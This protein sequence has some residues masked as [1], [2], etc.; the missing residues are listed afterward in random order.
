M[1]NC[2]KW[3]IQAGLRENGNRFKRSIVRVN[4]VISGNLAFH[5]VSLLP[6]LL[7]LPLIEFKLELMS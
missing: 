1:R 6:T 4:A 2:G 3:G 5:T 7:N